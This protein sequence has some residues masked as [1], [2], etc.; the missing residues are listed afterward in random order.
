MGPKRI[1]CP[2]CFIYFYIQTVP[3]GVKSWIFLI[4]EN[5]I[6]LLLI[7]VSCEKKYKTTLLFSQQTLQT[8]DTVLMG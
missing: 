1:K 6:Y 2:F 7:T 5:F 3:S 8:R 4:L